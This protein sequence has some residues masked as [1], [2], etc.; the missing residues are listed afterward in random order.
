[1]IKSKIIFKKLEKCFLVKS[2]KIVSEA[3]TNGMGSAKWIFN[4]EWHFAEKLLF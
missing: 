4:K 1:M 3:K 2:D